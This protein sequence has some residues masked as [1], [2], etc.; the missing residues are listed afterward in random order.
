MYKMC[1]IIQCRDRQ[2]Y[3]K[4]A[5]KDP[6]WTSAQH[7]IVQSEPENYQGHSHTRCLCSLKAREKE[8]GKK[9][10]KKTKKGYLK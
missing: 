6:V 3:L 2:S 5:L 1:L 8:R 9:M 7:C 10:K 4:I